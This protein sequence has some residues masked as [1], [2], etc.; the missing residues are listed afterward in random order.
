MQWRNEAQRQRGLIAKTTDGT[1]PIVRC[2]QFSQKPTL[3]V[4]F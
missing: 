4:P 2:C 3:G 1:E